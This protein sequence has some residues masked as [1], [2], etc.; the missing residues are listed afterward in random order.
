MTSFLC[1]VQKKTMAQKGKKHEEVGSSTQDQI[2]EGKKSKVKEKELK[3][4]RNS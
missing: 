3:S 1:L 2:K 4:M